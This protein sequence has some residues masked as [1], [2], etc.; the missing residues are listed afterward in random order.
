[1]KKIAVITFAFAILVACNS[2]GDAKTEEKKDTASTQTAS[3]DRTSNPAYQKG[4]ELEAKSDCKTCHGIDVRIQGPSYK[5]IANKYA[6][7]PDT[8]IGHLA[9]KIIAGGSGVWP[10]P[11][12][13]N[14]HPGMPKEDAE[15]LVKYVFLFKD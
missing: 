4:L 8:I 1:M 11:G 2:G 6:S 7:L 14:P 3:N 15:A 5:E 12:L 10:V 13:M 9:N